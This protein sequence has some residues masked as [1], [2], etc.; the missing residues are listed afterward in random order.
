MAE[1]RGRF[2]LFT[3]LGITL[4][5]QNHPVAIQLLNRDPDFSW[6]TIAVVNSR[7]KLLMWGCAIE[8]SNICSMYAWFLLYIY[9]YTHITYTHVE[10]E[11]ER[12]RKFCQVSPKERTLRVQTFGHRNSTTKTGNL[13][14]RP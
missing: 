6:L 12:E 9:I 5:C 11:G 10:R 14:L 1:I 7:A 8:M 4:Q 3:C 13:F 2:V